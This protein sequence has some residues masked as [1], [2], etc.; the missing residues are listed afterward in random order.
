MSTTALMKRPRSVRE[1]AERANAG[2][3]P[4]RFALAE[5]LDEVYKMSPPVQRFALA[6]EPPLLD[7][8]NEDY[9]DWQDAYLAAV[10]EHLSRAA[11]LPIPAWVDNPGRFLKRPYFANGGIE[12]LKAMLLAESPL[13]FRRRMIFVEAQP[14]R[15]A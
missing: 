2:Q 4:F 5:M 1:V 10:A 7:P 6:Y 9:G 3:Q 8:S 13:S 11:K 14:L 15:R 12:S